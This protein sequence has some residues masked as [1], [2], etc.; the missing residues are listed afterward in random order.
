M[1]RRRLWIVVATCL[2][3]VTLVTTGW[4]AGLVGDRVRDGGPLEPDGPYVWF[5]EAREGIVFSDGMQMLS[6]QGP[7]RATVR[8]VT[9]QGG[10]K[11]LDFLGAR[12]GLPGRPYDFQQ[13]MKGFPPKAVPAR[14]QVPAEGAVLEP[15]KSYMLILGYRVISDVL[16]RRRSVTVEYEAA[17]E[18]YRRVS[19]VSLVACPPPLTDVTCAR[20]FEPVEDLFD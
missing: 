7:D 12:V 18:R 5:Y 4:W 17:G 13:Q 6:L 3:V 19:Q 1:R 14:L 20:K 11:A 2:L 9:V 16:D 15:G 8:S 10:G